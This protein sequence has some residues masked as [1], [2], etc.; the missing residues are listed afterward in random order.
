MAGPRLRDLS[1]RLS[2]GSRARLRTADREVE[3]RRERL[4]LLDPINVLRRGFSITRRADGSLLRD[5][6][7][8]QAGEMLTTRLSGGSVESEVRRTRDTRDGRRAGETTGIN[9]ENKR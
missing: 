5:T 1:A 4:R 9:E 2:S 6:L 3:H 8:L 7:G